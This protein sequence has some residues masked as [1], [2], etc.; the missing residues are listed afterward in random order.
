[1]KK[2]ALFIL[3]ALSMNISQAAVFMDAKAAL[4]PNPYGTVYPVW[5]TNASY[6]IWH[7]LPY[8]G[9][10]P[11]NFVIK[12]DPLLDV[13][14]LILVMGSSSW[15]AD[16]KFMFLGVIEGPG[17]KFS[18][19]QVRVELNSTDPLNLFHRS[20]DLGNFPYSQQY[21]GIK[22]GRDAMLG[23]GDD[24]SL[25]R[26]AANQQVDALY[27]TIGAYL[28]ISQAELASTLQYLNNSAPFDLTVTF[29]LT[30][31]DG[32]VYSNSL[33]QTV[34]PEPPGL[35]VITAGLLLFS[36]FI[37]RRFC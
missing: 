10:P 3:L 24:T 17:Q 26:G 14:S 21:L 35:P 8:Y 7:S 37:K 20:I 31:K 6:A 16:N 22:T 28:T 32:S 18:L 33:T 15:P 13:A 36:F 4:A 9:D 25:D 34:V 12:G 23:T 2:V 1:M 29:S 30:A 27:L 19:S 5:Q 11:A